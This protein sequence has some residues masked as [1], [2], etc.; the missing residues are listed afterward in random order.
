MAE[1]LKRRVDGLSK[2]IEQFYNK[3]KETQEAHRSDLEKRI[4]KNSR[5]IQEVYKIL[6]EIQDKDRVDL[7]AKIERRADSKKDG[8]YHYYAYKSDIHYGKKT[9]RYFVVNWSTNEV[10][11]KRGD[12][13]VEVTDPRDRENLKYQIFQDFSKD[14]PT[15]FKE[16][17]DPEND[18]VDPYFYEKLK[19][20]WAQ[21]FD[22]YVKK[23]TWRSSKKPITSWVAV[24]WYTKRV[25]QHSDDKDSK[26]GWLTEDE[27]EV[28]IMNSVSKPDLNMWIHVDKPEEYLKDWGLPYEVKEEKDPYIYYENDAYPGAVC[29]LDTTIDRAYMFLFEHPLDSSAFC[30]SWRRADN[31]QTKDGWKEVHP[32]DIKNFSYFK[33]FLDEKYREIHINLNGKVIIKKEN[34]RFYQDSDIP[35]FLDGRVY[36]LDVSQ[37]I[38]Y[39]FD[40]LKDGDTYFAKSFLK[41]ENLNDEKQFREVDPWAIKDYDVLD[42]SL[43]PYTDDED[44]IYEPNDK[45]TASDLAKLWKDKGFDAFYKEANDYAWFLNEYDIAE[46]NEE[47]IE[48]YNEHNRWADS[49]TDEKTVWS[50]LFSAIAFFDIDKVAAQ[51][52]RANNDAT[53]NEY[54]ITSVDVKDPCSVD[55]WKK[56]LYDCLKGV[57]EDF[58]EHGEATEKHT[59][60]SY[61][62]GRVHL[63][64]ICRYYEDDDGG[65]YSIIDKIYWTD[66]ESTAGDDW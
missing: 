37:N 57:A 28:I 3:L 33:K 17:D 51:I 52:A 49:A 58:I 64:S 14:S 63:D 53:T 15:R 55:E 39:E 6:R 45:V 9:D 12:V 36:A 60:K 56:C 13:E 2:K 4:N 26:N 61:Q 10:Y 20:E 42:A 30:R 29:A 31:F 11:K 32:H 59:F 38:A 23:I 47:D 65:E 43:P 24:D 1:D 35:D 40:Y 22:F 44:E 16:S 50:R 66:E 27:A 54:L 41:S 48:A 5:D 7:D 34:Y 46:K 8:K 19:D 62:R 25:Y 18:V 21:H